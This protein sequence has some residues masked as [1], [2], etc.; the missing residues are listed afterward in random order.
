MQRRRR[1]DDDIQTSRDEW[2][3]SLGIISVTRLG[4]LSLSLGAYVFEGTN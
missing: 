4:D 1:E 2:E 3:G